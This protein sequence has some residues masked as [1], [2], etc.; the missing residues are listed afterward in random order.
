MKKFCREIKIWCCIN[1]LSFCNKQCTLQQDYAKSRTVDTRQQHDAHAY[2]TSIYIQKIPLDIQG[3]T[4]QY[5][6]YILPMITT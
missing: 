4:I 5:V 6:C 1:R 2:C 3:G